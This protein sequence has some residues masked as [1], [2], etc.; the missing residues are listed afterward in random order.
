M[1]QPMPLDDVVDDKHWYT[2]D[3]VAKLFSVDPKTVG[4][5]AKSGK[6]K[7]KGIE[8]VFTPGGHRRYNKQHIDALR[9]KMMETGSV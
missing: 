4:R 7:D 5:W 8:I 1:T 2:T 6:L 3:D 9:E